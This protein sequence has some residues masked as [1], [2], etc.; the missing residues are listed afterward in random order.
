MKIF[1]DKINA[2][3][4]LIG[5]KYKKSYSQCGEDI[6]I[7][8]LLKMLNISKPFYIDIG[9]NDPVVYSNTYS[10]YEK[11]A[12][13]ILVEPNPALCQKIRIK[14]PRDIVLEV[15]VGAKKGALTYFMF[16]NHSLN[17]FSPEKATGAEK[18]GYLLAKKMEVTIKTFEE[19]VREND[20]KNIDLLSLDVEGLDFEILQSIDFS[21]CRPK[22]ITVETQSFGT[23]ENGTNVLSIDKLLTDKEYEIAGMTPINKIFIDKNIKLK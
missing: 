10:F 11:G 7:G 23:Y 18:K 1:K 22:I 3:R 16:D 2:V 13:G 4:Y 6:I 21:I 17:T 8:R 19:I 20:V 12:H 15:G 14:R 9:A 5:P